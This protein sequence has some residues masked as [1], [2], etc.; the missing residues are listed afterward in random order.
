M[1]ESG[2][3]TGTR[4]REEAEQ[5]GETVQMQAV[6]MKEKGREELREQL[7]QRTTQVG[8]EARS[9]AGLLRRSGQELQSQ[10]GGTA[11]ARVAAG[12]ADR[13]E[14]AGGYLERARG[15]DVLR[16]AERFARE[17]PWLV[18]G[19][20]AAAGLAAS[21][22]LKASSE[23]RYGAHGQSGHESWE[24][25]RDPLES[26]RYPSPPTVPVGPTGTGSAPAL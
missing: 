9:F 16:D 14:R 15:E 3:G 7:D 25:H 10:N 6:E 12:V 22:F 4:L 20:A 23:R 1:S 11:T 18:A 17:R 13:I 19:V 8:H 5:L 26:T 2:Q 21:R 24:R